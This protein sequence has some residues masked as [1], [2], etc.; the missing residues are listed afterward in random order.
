[1]DRTEYLQLCQKVSMLKC[2]L[3]DAKENVPHDLLVKHNGI[4]YYPQAYELSYD[5]GKTQHKAILHDLKTHSI[6]YADLGK[7]VKYD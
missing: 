4:A 6:T 5:N 2:G 7:V 1:M 3:H